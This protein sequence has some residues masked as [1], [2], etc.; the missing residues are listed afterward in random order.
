[1]QIGD[2]GGKGGRDDGLVERGE[3]HPE[4]QGADDEHDPTV[5][6]DRD[7]RLAGQLGRRSAHCS[8]RA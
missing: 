3:E 6:Q 2:D 1:M 7:G 8:L 5:G 4:H